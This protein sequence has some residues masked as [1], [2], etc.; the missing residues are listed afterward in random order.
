MQLD[1]SPFRVPGV[2]LRLAPALV[3]VVLGGLLI[4]SGPAG[5]F[6]TVHALGQNA[7]HEMITRVL[8]CFSQ[9]QA[10]TPCFRKRSM[11]ILAGES[12]S[13]G[14]VGSPDIP[15]YLFGRPYNHCDDGDYNVIGAASYPKTEAEAHQQLLSCIKWAQTRISWAVYWSRLLLSNGTINFQQARTDQSCKLPNDVDG[16]DVNAKCAI[17]NE[18]GRAMHAAE[19]FWSHS[20]WAD[21]ANPKEPV[22][23]SNQPGLGRSDVPNYFLSS[24]NGSIPPDSYWKFPPNLVTGCDD[25]APLSGFGDRILHSNLSKDKGL[26]NPNDGKTSNPD[27]QRGRVGNNFELAVTGARNQTVALWNSYVNTLKYFYGNAQAE[28]MVT[29]LTSDTPW[30]SCQV[31]GRANNAYTPPAGNVSANRTVTASVVN[32][33]GVNLSCTSADM[34]YGEWGVMA[35]DTIGVGATGTFKALSNGSDTEGEVSYR[36]GSG[37]IGGVQGASVVIKWNNPLIGYN[38]YSCRA[39]A[40]FRCTVGGQQSGNDSAPT[41]T[42]S[43]S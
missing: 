17:L 36:L 12:G 32:Q 37:T 1:R 13:F 18:L 28:L 40:G 27:T 8:S 22:S 19:D 35:P 29:A 11:N 6:G 7:E 21:H 25:S 33:S 31:G 5:A 23:A 2:G 34:N 39:N 38:S 16:F 15:P 20:N 43:P 24:H 26:I 14:A 9:K 4:P 42:V 3:F 30:T 10:P 41:F